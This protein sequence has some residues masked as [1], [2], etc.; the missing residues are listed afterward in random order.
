MRHRADKTVPDDES[1]AVG[2]D[3]NASGYRHGEP[4]LVYQ[5]GKVA[6][7]SIRIGL[8]R[9]VP[10]AEIYHVHN[11]NEP[12]LAAFEAECRADPAVAARQAQQLAEV[13]QQRAFRERICRDGRRWHTV[14]VAREP[15]AHLV[16]SI[17]QSLDFFLA[18]IGAGDLDFAAQRDAIT[19]YISDVLGRGLPGSAAYAAQPLFERALTTALTWFD[20]E[21]RPA[22]GFD[23]LV[24][25]FPWRE[26]FAI[27]RH[28]TANV[29][30]LRFEDLPATASR[31]VEAWLDK[32]RFELASANRTHEKPS[33]RLYDAVVSSL[34]LP[35]ALL[36]QLYATRYARAF[37]TEEE[38]RALAARWRA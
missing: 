36:E 10:G 7:H 23:M 30:V 4:L 14:S 8:E 16:S 32:P 19:A 37:Y 38:R 24:D 17:F 2:L 31:G 3:L 9:L 21:L 13:A 28:D 34:R 27:R 35:P 1:A 6:S 12:R 22:T 20:E 25:P 33:G 18:R 29:L 26:G 11:L 5:M 15:V